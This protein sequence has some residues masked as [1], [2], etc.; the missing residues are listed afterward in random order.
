M[1]AHFAW[2][3]G[4]RIH[5]DL[6]RDN[7]DSR[8]PMWSSFAWHALGAVAICFLLSVT[9]ILAEH[10]PT[11]AAET[12]TW[13]VMA[14]TGSAGG[15]MVAAARRFYAGLK[16]LAQVAPTPDPA[17][18]SLRRQ[19]RATYWFAV[20]FLYGCGGCAVFAAVAFGSGH[21]QWLDWMPKT[22][23]YPLIDLLFG[24]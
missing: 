12:D 8:W 24:S 15:L 5:D 23:P 18:T 4:H 7:Q 13:L 1:V 9:V 11:S 6:M 20:I 17:L 14:V 19:Y 2:S 10:R 16:L 22:N 21:P 3:A